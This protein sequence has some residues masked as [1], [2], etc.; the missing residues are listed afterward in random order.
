MTSLTRSLA[1]AAFAMMLASSA[2]GAMAPQEFVNKA[3]VGGVFEVQSSETV[4]ANA[5]ANASAAIRSFAEKM[6]TDHS[7]ANEKL[8]GIAGQQNLSVPAGLD[9]EHMAKL[10]ELKSADS[11]MASTYSKMQVQAHQEAIQLFES[12]AQQGDNSALVSFARATLPTLQ[13]HRE[14][15]NRLPGGQ[16]VAAQQTDPAQTAPKEQ[17]AAPAVE[18]P[19]PKPVPEQAEHQVRAESLLGVDVSNGRDTIGKVVD[20][21]VTEDGRVDAIV[22]GVGGFLGIGQKRVALAW[23]S[24]KLTKQNDKRVFLVSA[25]ADQLKAMP[26]FKTLEDKAADAQAASAQQRMQQEQ[27]QQGGALGVKPAPA[28]QPN[29]Q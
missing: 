10:D 19:A 13:M 16:P 5:G 26:D 4:L 28:P 17:P 6:V 25:T 2:Y 7:A 14:M 12:Y 9:Q 8:K 20:L 22:V 24:A 29:K 1:A 27:Q 23:D 11:A 18:A 21:V 3:A 15:A